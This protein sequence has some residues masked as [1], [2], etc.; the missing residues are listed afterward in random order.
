MDT[1]NFIHIQ[2]KLFDDDE[3]DYEKTG[4][5]TQKTLTG[6]VHNGIFNFVLKKNTFSDI[7][8][9]PDFPNEKKDIRETVPVII[10]TGAI[11]SFE[12]LND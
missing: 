10:N 2:I 8:I 4:I 1:R 5:V 12:Q 9:Y 7:E 3:F 6:Y 11:C